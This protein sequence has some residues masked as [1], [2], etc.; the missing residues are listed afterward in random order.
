MPGCCILSAN[1]LKIERF[2]KI[3]RGGTSTPGYLVPFS[4]IKREQGKPL[5]DNANLREWVTPHASAEGGTKNRCATSIFLWRS[6]LQEPKVSANFCRKL[7]KLCDFY[8]KGERA[9]LSADFCRNLNL[10]K[11]HNFLQ[12]FVDLDFYRNLQKGHNFL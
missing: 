4:G 1:C 11:G 2:R 5:A 6:C 7:C 12:I 10:Q 9:Q 3:S 8:R